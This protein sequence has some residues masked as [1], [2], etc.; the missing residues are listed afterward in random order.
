MNC[1]NLQTAACTSS[2]ASELEAF[3]IALA[4][5]SEAFP[6]LTTICTDGHLG[7]GALMRLSP[8]N[9]VLDGWHGTK[10]MGKNM[11]AACTKKVGLVRLES[12]SEDPTILSQ[13][14]H[15]GESFLSRHRSPYWNGCRI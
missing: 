11:K 7:I 12:A 9:H 3:K 4:E 13:L 10:T 8:L 5:A 2:S 1:V 6:K 14:T 15:L